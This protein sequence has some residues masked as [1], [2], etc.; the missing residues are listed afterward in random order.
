MQF[1]WL[2]MWTIF[3]SNNHYRAK[4]S[5]IKL[6]WKKNTNS[7]VNL[8]SVCSKKQY[9]LKKKKKSICPSH[10]AALSEIKK[11]LSKGKH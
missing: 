5:P 7:K 6:I 4:Q 8:E 2:Q 11:E 1:K 10:F 3:I 9:F